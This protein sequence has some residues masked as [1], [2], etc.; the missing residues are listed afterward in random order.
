MLLMSAFFLQKNQRF[1]AT[2]V[3]LLKTIV[4]ELRWRFSSSV[5]S[6]CKKKVTFSGN[7]S[8]TGYA[9]G[10]RLL[11]A[12]KLATNW[13]NDNNI[14]VCNMTSSPNFFDVVLFLL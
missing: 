3:P 11:D 13:K 14:T 9:S 4:S 10:I 2:T 1:L 7:L 6:F 8:F 12:S 5:F